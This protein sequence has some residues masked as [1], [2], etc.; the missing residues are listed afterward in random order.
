MTCIVIAQDDALTIGRSLAALAAQTARSAIEVLVVVSGSLPTAAAARRAAPDAEVIEVERPVWPGEARNIGLARARGTFVSFPGSHVTLEPGAL[1]ARLAAHRQ[2]YAMVT[3]T[4]LNG[5]PG[6]AGWAAY[7]LENA[8]NLPGLPAGE[9][10]FPP[11]RCSYLRAA[12]DSVGEFPAVRSGEDTQVNEALWAH[13]YR[14]YRE[15]AIRLV[16]R[17]PCGS[18]SE[19]FRHQ[20]IRGLGWGRMIVDE[21]DAGRLLTAPRLRHWTLDM[22]PGRLCCGSSPAA[23]GRPTTACSS[24]DSSGPP[25]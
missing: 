11:T 13:G 15:P 2:G 4:L 12:L 16:H 21:H 9:L 24:V 14:A 23:F 17:N 22:L 6:W 3:G 10:S 1:E 5:T 7:F 19:F 20:R 8:A 25:R 18:V